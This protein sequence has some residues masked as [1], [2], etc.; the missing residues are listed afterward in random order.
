MN[1]PNKLTLGRLVITLIF[2]AVMSVDFAFQASIGLL[3]FIIAS[4][5]DYLDGM[6]A[7][8]HGLVTTFGKLMDPLVD[9]ILIC[10][11]YVILCSLPD[12]IPPWAVVIILAREF[13]VTGLRLIATSQGSVLAADSLGKWKTTL[14][15]T[16]AIYFLLFLATRE[17]LFSF[18]APLY[19]PTWMQPAVMGNLLVGLTDLI[20]VI[21][22][23]SYIWSNRSLVKDL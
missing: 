10:S 6:L 8:K 21:S 14:Q 4:I 18:L 1:L 3:L 20:T 5:T 15:I 19:Q 12:S 23:L 11:A 13:L 16:T 22:G 9:K 17:S 7:R 2:V